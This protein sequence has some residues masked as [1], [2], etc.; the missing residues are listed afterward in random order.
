MVLEYVTHLL[1]Y[2]V[3]MTVNPGFAGQKLTGSGLMKIS[4]CKAWLH[5]AGLSI[6]IEVDGNVSFDNIPRMVAAG[7]DILVTGTSS[8][9]NQPGSANENLQKIRAA[10]DTGLQQRNPL[11]AGQP[12]EG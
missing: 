6:P 7:A 12:I 2:L 10:I 3:V 4:D 1:D 9:F 8:L 11:L 5:R